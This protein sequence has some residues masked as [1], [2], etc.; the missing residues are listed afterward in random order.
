VWL[1][2]AKF[3]SVAAQ[4]V[5]FGE[6]GSE[7]V[8]GS[9]ELAFKSDFLPLWTRTPHNLLKNNYLWHR[10]LGMAAEI[11]SVMARILLKLKRERLKNKAVA[12]LDFVDGRGAV[13]QQD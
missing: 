1:G 4:W 9:A 10:L 12:D 8:Q 7:C 3:Y 13:P 11:E 6:S 5:T 2:L